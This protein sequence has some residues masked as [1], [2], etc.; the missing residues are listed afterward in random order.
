MPP[1]IIN[2]LL[3]S[4]LIK[5]SALYSIFNVLNAA[6]PFLLIPFLSRSLTPLEYGIITLY[7][8]SISFLMP[9]ISMNLQG[10]ITNKFYSKDPINISEYIGNAVLILLTTVATGIFIVNLFSIEIEAFIKFPSNWLWSIIVV[11]GA[12]T[13]IQICLVNWQVEGKIFSFG[14]FQLSFSLINFSL[15][16]YLIYY[17]NLKWEG[18]IISHTLISSIWGIFAFVLLFLRKRVNFSFNKLYIKNALNFGVPLIPHALGGFL[19]A[20][21]DKVLIANMIGVEATGLYGVGFQVGSVLSII[22]SAFNLAYVPWLFSNLK[23]DNVQKKQK[24]VRFTYLYFLILILFVVFSAGILPF[25]N[26]FFLGE[27]FIESYSISVWILVGF[28]FNGMYLMVTNYIFYVEKTQY[29]GITT[30]I[31]GI[32]NVYLCYFMINKIGI[33]GGAISTCIAYFSSFII[34]WY[35]SNLVCP[36]PW[37][38][39]LNLK[40]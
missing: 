14:L 16:L 31:V 28:A 19:I 21:T 35:L 39:F 27:K 5:Q 36:M 34:T 11:C 13:L 3:R 32:L 9:F 22:T 2:K 24:I 33:V 10:A 30:L 12:Q 7:T 29:L 4:A 20:M 26:A 17:Q 37:F 18:R 40:K 25:I 8:T 15:T 38:Y 1:I 23:E 6:I